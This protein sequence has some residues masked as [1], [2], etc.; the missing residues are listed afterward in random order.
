MNRCGLEHTSCVDKALS[1]TL[2]HTSAPRPT[3]RARP[4]VRGALLCL[5]LCLGVHDSVAQRPTRADEKRAPRVAV[6][7]F[8]MEQTDSGSENWAVSLGD[9][10]EVGL[11]Q[12][13]VATFERRQIRLVLGERGLLHSSMIFSANLRAAK[14]PSVDY[15][16]GGTV[17]RGT[18][19]QFTILVSLVEAGSATLENSFAAGGHYPDDWEPAV[20]KLVT[21]IS[22]HLNRGDSVNSVAKSGAKAITW[23]PEAAQPFFK[24][25]AYYAA[26]DFPLALALFRRARALDPAYR[27]AWLWEAKCYKQ[28]GFPEQ[29]ELILEK[30]QLT[31][32]SAARRA[33]GSG[34]PL[35]AVVASAT[36][37][38]EERL[39]FARHLARSGKATVF[40]P[41]SIGATT[42][43]MDLQLTGEMATPPRGAE[44]WLAVDTVVLLDRQS[45]AGGQPGSLRVRQQDLATGRIVFEST[46]TDRPNTTADAWEKLAG[47]LPYRRRTGLAGESAPTV[48]RPPRDAGDPSALDVPERALIVALDQASRRPDDVRALIALADRFS[49]WLGGLSFFNGKRDYPIEFQQQI[50]MLDRAIETIGRQKSYKDASFW[51]ASALW[52]KREARVNHGWARN[53]EG[54]RQAIPLK[55]DFRLLEEWFP[56][57]AELKDLTEEVVERRST[58][59]VVLSTSI[60]PVNRRYVESIADEATAPAP[61]RPPTAGA[62]A[63]EKLAAIKKHWEAGNPAKAWHLRTTMEP[64]Q[65]HGDAVITEANRIFGQEFHRLIGKEQDDF[66]RFCTHVQKGE[67]EEALA[68]ASALLRCIASDRRLEVIDA[69][70]RI[71]ERRQGCVAKVRFLQDEV[72]RFLQDYDPDQTNHLPRVAAAKLWDHAGEERRRGHVDHCIRIYEYIRA[73]DHFP[74]TQRLA[75]AYELAVIHFERWQLFEALDHL[76]DILKQTEG[77]DMGIDRGLVVISWPTLNASATDLLKLIRLAGDAEVD[78]RSCCG[79]KTTPPIQDAH[80]ASEIQ[81][82]YRAWQEVPW[83]SQGEKDRR[84]AELVAR[85]GAVVP[86][87]IGELNKPDYASAELTRIVAELG[88]NAAPLSPYLVADIFKRSGSREGIFGALGAIGPKAACA[89]PIMILASQFESPHVQINARWALGQVGVPP[90][91]TMPYL[92]RLL[93]HHNGEVRLLAARAMASVEKFDSHPGSHTDETVIEIAKLWWEQKSGEQRSASK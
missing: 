88:T 21:T 66:A 4:G 60:K 30:L 12:Q 39:S 67:D 78:Y 83:K 85:G 86:L 9:I 33:L 1:G 34:L 31:D 46:A 84:L 43:E 91:E 32:Q 82:L 74:Q 92:A 68:L 47:E 90:P 19:N 80:D 29:A 56:G 14:L 16:V 26:G 45:P 71:I 70:A 2:N 72:E 11:Q 49:P 55:E 20:R 87:L 40:D 53:I 7:D 22:A 54:K 63:A 13:G 89:I 62:T 65:L 38:E 77:S 81:K 61:E 48:P 36:V 73:S 17:R 51:L 10:V 93:Y 6:L 58:K 23:L 3:R 76:R 42:R 24:A 8:P 64:I 50:R 25:T 52:R 79:N 59:G 18:N 41:D 37:A 28:L 57:C 69:T 75:A 44:L 27:L 35:A 15:F 5:L